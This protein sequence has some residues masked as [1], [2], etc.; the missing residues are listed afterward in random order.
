M[1]SPTKIASTLQLDSQGLQGIS[2]S[3]SMVATGPFLRLASEGTPGL[4]FSSSSVK[5]PVVEESEGI[6]RSF[7]HRV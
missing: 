6:H 5:K 1:S 2:S 7:H 3:H 4:T